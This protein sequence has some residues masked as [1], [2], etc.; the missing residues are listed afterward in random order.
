M[1]A[2]EIKNIIEAGLPGCQAYVLGEDE[3]HFEAAVV[4]DSFL[5]KS[6]IAQHKLV[7]ATLGDRMQQG[8]IHALSLKTYT[9]QQWSEK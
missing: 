5:G 1:Q 8:V 4:S 3:V 7:F 2:E 9:Q 6:K